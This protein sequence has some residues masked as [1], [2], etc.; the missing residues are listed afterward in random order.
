MEEATDPPPTH[1][2]VIRR[3]INAPVE[4]VWKMWTEP[5]HVMGWW[6]PQ[7]Y[8][9]PTCKIDLRPGGRYVFCMRA[10][11]DQGG[12]DAYTAGVY[13]RV[14]HQELLEFTQHLADENGN[15]LASQD[16]P[17]GFPETQLHTV[18]FT[19]RGEMTELT[20]VEY[21]WPISHMI[22]FSYAG[23][24]QSIDKLGDLLDR[25]R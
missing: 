22:V 16:L 19:R 1:D 11:A 23:M 13:Q 20:I 2:L 24:H 5:E 3:I 17:P 21:A 18:T 25:P 9:S 15:P 4:M 10:P 12:Q 7:F 14:V 6:G 8:T